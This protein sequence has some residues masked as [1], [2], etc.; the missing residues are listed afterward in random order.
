MEN[1][2]KF[3]MKYSLGTNFDPQLIEEI[4]ICDK[5]KSIKSVFGKLRTDLLGGGRSSMILPKLTMNQLEE[6][7]SLCHKNGLKFNYLLNPM[8]LGNK[9]LNPRD[10]KKIIKYID[11]L[12]SIGVDALTVNSPYL[13]ELIKKQFPNFK[14]T[15]GLYAYIFNIQHV[16]Y[17]QELGADE[18]TLHHIL[19]RNFEL[20]EDFLNYTKK[21]NIELRLIANNVCLHDCPYQINHGTGQAHASQKGHSSSKLYLDYNLLSCNYNKIK[22]P[23]K[24]IASEWIR[25]EDIKYYEELCDKTGNYNFSI[26]LL[27]RTKTTE[28]L[29]RVVNAYVSR[30]YD[31]NLID[32][33]TWPTT[34]DTNI[35][36]KLPMYIRAITGQYNLKELKNFMEVFNLPK[37]QIDNK[38]LDGFLEKFLN[39]Y[40]CNRRICN[41][42]GEFYNEREHS[43]DCNMCSYCRY[44]AEK[45]VVYD[46]EEVETWIKKADNVFNVLK[47]SRIFM[48]KK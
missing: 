22:N 36:H 47:N 42:N 27:E 4:K 26:K 8:C 18:L 7:I 29:K 45:A 30:T 39:G 25:P 43:D 10:H 41:D 24:I 2:Q 19:N 3:N 21:S 40:E 12:G 5:E 15:I 32:I 14:V 37:I 34:R 31:G 48:K 23:T 13:C 1:S 11:N 9:E 38:K 44:Y 17:W 6:Y 46:K 35:I 16:K 28:F 33:L 20:L